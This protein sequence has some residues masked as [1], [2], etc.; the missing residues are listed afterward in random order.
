MT[1]VEIAAKFPSMGGF[2]S[3]ATGAAAKDYYEIINAV[4]LGVQ[5][6]KDLML[7]D[8]AAA[9]AYRLANEEL[10]DYRYI[11]QNLQAQLSNIR[12]QKKSWLREKMAGFSS[13]YKRLMIEDLER[14]ERDLMRHMK[15]DLA[16]A[17]K[18]I[19]FNPV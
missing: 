16:K 17:H 5:T 6:H 1:A 2:L 8:E 10:F 13:S 19:G 12:R 18:Y 3:P 7:S 11:E 15:K 14:Q 9:E 4:E